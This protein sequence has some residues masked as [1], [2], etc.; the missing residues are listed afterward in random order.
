MF[1]EI[2]QTRF[3]IYSTADQDT[4]TQ[5]EISERVAALYRL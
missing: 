5:R 4:G 1:S 2:L 3:L